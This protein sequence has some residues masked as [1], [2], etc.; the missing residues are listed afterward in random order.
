MPIIPAAFPRTTRTAAPFVFLTCACA[1]FAGGCF[2]A[3]RPAPKLAFTGFAHPVIPPPVDI[4]LADA[5]DVS[6]EAEKPVSPLAVP[7]GAPTRPRVAAAP[8]PEHAAPD[9]A[10]DPLMAPELTD[11]QLSA[12]RAATEKSLAIAERNLNFAKGKTLNTVQQDLVSKIQG[13]VDS[14]REAMKNNDW[15]RAQIQARK[16]EILSQEIFPNP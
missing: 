16:A 9:K 6:V 12:A 14:A 8:T 5:P 3:K 2:T 15:P 11:A 13:F 4:A 10:A 7:H 1:L